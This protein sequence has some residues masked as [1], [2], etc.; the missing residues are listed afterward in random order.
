[1][2]VYGFDQLLVPGMDPVWNTVAVAGNRI[3]LELGG[4]IPRISGSNDAEEAPTRSPSRGEAGMP[5]AAR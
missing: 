3:I 4:G 2:P 5:G 1:V